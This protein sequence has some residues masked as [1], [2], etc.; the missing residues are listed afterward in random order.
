MT[1]KLIVKKL[2]MQKEK[3]ITRDIIKKF[4]EELNIDYYTVISY[5]L[6]NKYLIRILRGVFYVNSL[7]ERKKKKA[8]INHFE[9]IGKALE[10]KGVNNWY[11]G[12]ETALKLNNITH[13]YFNITYVLSDSIFRKNLIEILGH[14]IKFIKLNKKLFR[15]GIIKN[16]LNYS[17]MEKAILDIAYLR[18]Y[19]SIPDEEII[20]EIIGFIKYCSKSKLKKYSKH[21]P[22]TV[23][24]IIR[25]VA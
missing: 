25:G 5:L 21:Y 16:N 7:E 11:F 20:N 8:D 10:I 15:F 9:A 12:L 1:L 24:K 17:D 3:F 19:N 6:S 18:K 23:Q 22:K 14:K 2:G 13:E 4:S